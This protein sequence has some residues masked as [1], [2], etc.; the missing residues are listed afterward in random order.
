MLASG[1]QAVLFGLFSEGESTEKPREAGTWAQKDLAR[2]ERPAFQLA[3]P[4]SWSLATAQADYDA[5]RNFSIDAPGD[6]YVAIQTFEAQPGDDVSALLSNMIKA[7][8]GPLVDT[9]SRSHFTQW[10]SFQGKGTHLKGKIMSMF[11]G[12]ARVFIGTEGSFGLIIVEYY[13]SEEIKEVM[14]AFE[15]IAQSFQLN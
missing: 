10:G 4:K 11:P 3:Y 8:D 6:S 12:G 1:A 14:P 15:L 13:F 7:F 5:D 9:Y 2:I